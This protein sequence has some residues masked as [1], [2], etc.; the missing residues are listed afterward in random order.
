MYVKGE[1]LKLGCGGDLLTSKLTTRQDSLNPTSSASSL[2][3]MRTV[4]SVSL[5]LLAT[6]TASA[7][8]NLIKCNSLVVVDGDTAR[9]DGQLLRD[10]GDGAPNVSGYDTPEKNGKCPKERALARKA[11]KRMA[12]LLR[13]EGLT[14]IDSGAVTKGRNN[15]VRL[16]VW[17]KLPDGRSI[18]S[19]MIQEGL[20]RVWTP[21][22][23]AN[24]CG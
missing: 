16:L 3:P 21:G 2:C 13:T 5:M 24:W 1:G 22:S 10:M 9:C 14:I 18:G 20:A 11:T 8:G 17:I 23:K 15:K 4:L 6:S 7:Q 19:I 12:Q